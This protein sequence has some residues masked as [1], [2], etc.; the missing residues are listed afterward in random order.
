MSLTELFRRFAQPLNQLGIP[1]MATGA[2]AAVV[3]GEPR[4]TLDLDLV[5]QISPQDISRF[6][7]AFPGTEFYVP[8]GRLPRQPG[9][10]RC[11]GIGAPPA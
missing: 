7:A 11:L 1:Y 6:V 2:L 4:L 3:Y 5:L 8:R 10:A 9:P